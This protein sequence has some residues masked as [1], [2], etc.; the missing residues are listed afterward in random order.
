MEESTEEAQHREDVLRMYHAT[1]EALSIISD[2]A[3]NTVSTPV[4]PPVDDEW[5]KPSESRLSNNGY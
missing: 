2:V 5:I 3:T 4:P 1:K